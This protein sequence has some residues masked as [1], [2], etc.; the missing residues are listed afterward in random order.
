M[1]DH[2]E[3]TMQAIA[4][5]SAQNGGP[6]I[7]DV[8]TAL[9]AVNDDAKSR[10]CDNTR[11]LD[12]LTTDSVACGIRVTALEKWH[13]LNDQLES[14]QDSARFRAAGVARGVLSD[15]AGT[16]ADKTIQTAEAAA[17]ALAEGSRQTWAMWGISSTIIREVAI[18]LGIVILTLYVT[19]KL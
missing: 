3:K 2:F 18:P 19:G 5:D 13:S 4:T 12:A 6:T 11:V 1:S 9:V 7:S 15:A 17:L 14:G 16:A 8:L 10:H